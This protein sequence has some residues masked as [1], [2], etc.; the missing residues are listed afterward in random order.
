MAP[1]SGKAEM[2]PKNHSHSSHKLHVTI[3]GRRVRSPHLIIE[4]Q[5]SDIH[6][7]ANSKKGKWNTGT[8]RDV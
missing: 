5:T 4:W 2:C 8:H 6:D 7:L 1:E 3:D